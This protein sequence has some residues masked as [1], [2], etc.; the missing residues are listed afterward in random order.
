MSG[1]ILLF[2]IGDA[3]GNLIWI[4]YNLIEEES[5]FSDLMEKK[6]E[7]GLSITDLLLLIMF[8]FATI[9]LYIKWQ[10]TRTDKTTIKDFF[11]KPRL[12]KK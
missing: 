7:Q 12:F 2:V 5:W 10:F 4:L 3:I 8:W 6:K 1:F 9:I 11:T